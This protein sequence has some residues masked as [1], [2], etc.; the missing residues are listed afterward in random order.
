[1]ALWYTEMKRNLERFKQVRKEIEVGKMS[2]QLVHLR[3][4]LQ[5]LKPMCVS[6]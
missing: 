6:I 5:K 4:F 1:M 3:T 2:G